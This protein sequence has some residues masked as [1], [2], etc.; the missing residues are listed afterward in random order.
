MERRKG[1]AENVGSREANGGGPMRIDLFVVAVS[2]SLL[3][4]LIG[5]PTAQAQSQDI[6]TA[7]RFWTSVHTG[8][9]VTL[10]HVP[11]GNPDNAHTIEVGQGAAAAHL[12]HGDSL[13]ACPECPE[14]C[15]VTPEKIAPG[16]HP[17]F[18]TRDGFEAR[19]IVGQLV[20]R[21]R[22]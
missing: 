11:P 14:P 4:L 12:A 8:L 1:Q 2:V 19:K 10:C 7:D 21:Q 20:P 15:D 5:L 13:G 22:S 18:P 17:A 3:V 16:K 6:G 9:L